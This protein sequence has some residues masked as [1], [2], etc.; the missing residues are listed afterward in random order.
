MAGQSL[1]KVL[2]ESIRRSWP[3]RL[4]MDE[5][6]DTASNVRCSMF[7]WVSKDEQEYQKEDEHEYEDTYAAAG[8]C[9]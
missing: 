8:H 9:I 1:P 4:M 5:Q 6:F 2:T 7:P 3:D